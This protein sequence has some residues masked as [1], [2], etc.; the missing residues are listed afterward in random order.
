MITFSS[1][2]CIGGG[3]LFALALFSSGCAT[4]PAPLNGAVTDRPAPERG[5]HR[6]AIY[7]D[8]FE[9]AA[10]VLPSPRDN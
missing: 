3:A 6:L 2:T 5:A 1:P 10:I 4:S 8:W 9:P 7:E